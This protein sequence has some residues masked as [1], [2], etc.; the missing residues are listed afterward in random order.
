MKR[1]QVN[2]HRLPDELVEAIEQRWVENVDK[3]DAE[4]R[5]GVGCKHLRLFD[6]E[7]I[8]GRLVEEW[9]SAP[10]EYLGTPSES[11]PPGDIER[12]SSVV[13][14]EVESDAPLAVDFRTN[15]PSIVALTWPGWTRV[16]ESSAEFLD[17]LD[18][19]GEL[20]SG[21]GT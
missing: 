9:K 7:Y 19:A 11:H 21:Q 5:L 15:P 18:P 17:A 10:A 3:G 13:I 20:R 8:T 12:E 4:L 1:Q 14:G 6:I 16:A 2:G